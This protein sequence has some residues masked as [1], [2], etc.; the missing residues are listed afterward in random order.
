MYTQ[1]AKLTHETK[2]KNTESGI[3]D[4]EPNAGKRI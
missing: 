2:Q 4:P 1:I 3:T